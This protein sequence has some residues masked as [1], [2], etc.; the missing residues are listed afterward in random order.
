MY[1][2]CIYYNIYILYNVYIYYTILY[3]M[4]IYIYTHFSWILLGYFGSSKIDSLG[5]FRWTCSSTSSRRSERQQLNCGEN[6]SEQKTRFV[7]QATR[8]FIHS[9][10]ISWHSF[11][12]Q[13]GSW[14]S[15]GTHIQNSRSDEATISPILSRCNY[16]DRMRYM[17][18]MI[19]I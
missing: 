18:V 10:N 12:Q 7:H 17:I 14:L 8:A 3:I 9:H 15:H 5:G 2:V 19:K 1:S 16:R 13:L 6:W 4:Y 11:E